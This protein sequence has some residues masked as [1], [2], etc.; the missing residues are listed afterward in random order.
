VLV[1]AHLRKGETYADLAIG[2]GIGTTRVFRYICEAL[3]VL[4]TMAPTLTEAIDVARHKAFVTLDGSLLRIDRVA[5][6]SG[7]DRPYY[8]GN[9][10]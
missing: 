6:T 5:M 3:E 7:R 1:I 8:S 9:T 10:G 4:A 2:F